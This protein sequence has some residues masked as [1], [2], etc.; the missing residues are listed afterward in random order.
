MIGD[1]PNFGEVFFP[2]RYSTFKSKLNRTS[3]C[4]FFFGAEFHPC[5]FTPPILAVHADVLFFHRFFLKDL[6]RH[7][8]RV[9]S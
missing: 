5:P 1:V 7:P 2:M 6:R 8:R 3:G 9:P 4:D